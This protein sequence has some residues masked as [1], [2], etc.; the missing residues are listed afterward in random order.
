MTHPF[1]R[2]R[3]SACTRPGRLALRASLLAPLLAVSVVC[4][5]HAAERAKGAEPDTWYAS[6]MAKT[7]RSFFLTHYWSKG[8]RLR[9]ETVLGGRRLITIVNGPTYYTLDPTRGIGLAIERSE[10]ARAGDAKRER[11]FGDELVALERAGGELVGEGTLN[12]QPVEQYRLTNETGRVEVWVTMDLKLPV[13]VVRFL[14]DA[15]ESDQTDYVNWLR[16]LPIDDRFFEPPSG[17][18]IE[19]IG[20]DDYVRKS[21]TQPLGPAPPF[22]GHLLHGEPDTDRAR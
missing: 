3:R 17:I 1:R 22:Y 6:A 7:D 15:G 12:G 8:A 20:Y 2:A 9:A 5:A 16:D 4:A 19:R 11:P 14:R 18:D 13:R 21:A 10:L